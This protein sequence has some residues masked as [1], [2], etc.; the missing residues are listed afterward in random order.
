M[1]EAH[2]AA[3][4]TLSQR[5]KA[6]AAPVCGLVPAT[7]SLGT[8]NSVLGQE[9]LVSALPGH[10]IPSPRFTLP[11]INLDRFEGVFL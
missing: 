3:Q 6:T 8:V 2:T 10:G 4:Q 9:C 5:T 11:V 1:Y 7:L